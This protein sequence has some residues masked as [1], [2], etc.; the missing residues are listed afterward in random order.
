MTVLAFSPLKKKTKT[1]L[2]KAKKEMISE[3]ITFST[4]F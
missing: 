3:V 4:I 2:K 1:K